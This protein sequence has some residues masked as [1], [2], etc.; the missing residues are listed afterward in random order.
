MKLT[1]KAGFNY[2]YRFFKHVHYAY[3]IYSNWT[4]PIGAVFGA[5]SFGA[6]LGASLA[7]PFFGVFLVNLTARMGAC[8]RNTELTRI[9]CYWF[10]AWGSGFKYGI[11]GSRLHALKV[12]GSKLTGGF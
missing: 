4:E 12:V 3:N 8:F 6:T 11:S 10:I 7:I 9:S 2:R 5:P 1:G